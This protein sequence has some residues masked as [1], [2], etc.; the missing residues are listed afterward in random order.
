MTSQDPSKLQQ[1]QSYKSLRLYVTKYISTQGA[2]ISVLRALLASKYSIKHI[3]A[4]DFAVDTL[5]AYETF[6][7]SEKQLGNIIGLPSQYSL[8]SQSVF[9]PQSEFECEIIPEL[10]NLIHLHRKCKK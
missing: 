9:D 8:F 4:C 5:H 3:L 1:D 2:L 7:F 6:C 10:N